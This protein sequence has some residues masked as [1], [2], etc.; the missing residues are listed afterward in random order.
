ML[1][2]D[3]RTEQL[4]F[5]DR[6][7]LP[8]DRAARMTASSDGKQAAFGWLC[9][10]DSVE[11]FSHQKNIVSV[12]SVDPNQRRWVAPPSDDM[13]MPPLPDPAADFPELL[14]EGFRL[15]ADK[16]VQGTLA[17]ALAIN[18]DGSRIALIEHGVWIWLRTAPAIGKWDPPIHA[19]NFVPAQRG[20]LRVF[21]G[22]GKELLRE[23]LPEPGLFEAGFGDNPD[24]IWCWPAAWF[25][26]GMAGTVWL[27]V[28]ANRR[29]AYRVDVSSRSA[30]GLTFPDAIADCAVN[31]ADG[32]TLVSCWDGRIYL[33]GAN[34]KTAARIEVGHPRAS[35]VEWQREVRY[36]RNGRRTC[37]PRR[38][39]RDDFLES[40]ACGRRIS[41]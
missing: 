37:A 33:I 41:N 29:N 27:P 24:E 35:G 25:A 9:F 30:R 14:A 7:L 32:P 23:W 18:R 1:H 36:R 40:R 39:R 2:A 21:D 20:R 22:A 17:T 34:D 26:R 16:L 15:R 8:T 10:R 38:R 28:D 19:L 13:V 4:R 12:W 3:G 31:P 5:E 11:G 6:N